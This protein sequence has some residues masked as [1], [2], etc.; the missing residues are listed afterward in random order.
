MSCHRGMHR[1]RHV[2]VEM[3]G[4][5]SKGVAGAIPAGKRQ[6]ARVRRGSRLSRRRTQEGVRHAKRKGSS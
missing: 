5:G 2:V 4:M 3:S 6:A 1:D